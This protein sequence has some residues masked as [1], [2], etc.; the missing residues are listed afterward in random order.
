MNS[1]LSDISDFETRGCISLV[2]PEELRAAVETV[3]LSWKRFCALPLATKT[4]VPYSNNADG[5]GYEL[6]DGIGEHVDHKENFDMT[7]SGVLWLSAHMDQIQD[8]TVLQFAKDMASLVHMLKPTVIDFA[9][10]VEDTYALLGITDEVT[11][12]EDVFFVRFIHY[13]NERNVGDV[14]AAP[15]VDNGAFTLHLFETAKGLE[16]MTYQGEWIEMPVSDGETVIIPGMQ[17]QHRSKNV[18]RALCH[19]VIETEMG[20]GGRYSAVCFVQLKLSPKFDKD[21]HGRQ[22]GLPAGYNYTM[23]YEEFVKLFQS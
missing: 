4:S 23:P 18:I 13:F 5:V 9:R 3:A 16:C 17:M 14:T 19:R 22:Q 12:Y 21:K 7:V 1:M 8:P 11:A 6:K 10:Q 15:H 20:S 2:Y